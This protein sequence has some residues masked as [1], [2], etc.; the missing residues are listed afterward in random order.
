MY[1][2][3]CQVKH[4]YYTLT[5]MYMIL[6]LLAKWLRRQDAMH[7]VLGSNPTRAS[8]LLFSDLCIDI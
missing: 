6:T 7:E 2:T 5:K 3:N 1:G 4:Y 8:F